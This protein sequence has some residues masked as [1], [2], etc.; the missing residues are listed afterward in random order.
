M[1]QQP[2]NSEIYQAI[3][4][5]RQEL[6]QRDEMLEDKVDKTYLRIQVFEAE[7]FPIKRFVYGLITI[8][9]AALVTAMMAVVLR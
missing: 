2:S 6:V 1:K 8:A 5:L 9:G 4:E 3:N 7:I